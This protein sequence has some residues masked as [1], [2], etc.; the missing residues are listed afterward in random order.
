MPS[1]CTPVELSQLGWA[2]GAGRQGVLFVQ[3]KVA[4]AH[5]D[6]AVFIDQQGFAMGGSAAGQATQQLD[7]EVEGDHAEHPVL[8]IHR[9]REGD[10][11]V[12]AAGIL[13]QAGDDLPALR[14]VFGEGVLPERLEQK[15]PFVVK[16]VERWFRRQVHEVAGRGVVHPAD[17]RVVLEDRGEQGIQAEC[18]IQLAAHGAV[19]WNIAKPGDGTAQLAGAL[20]ILTAGEHPALAISQWAQGAQRRQWRWIVV[21]ALQ[22]QLPHGVYL[23][24]EQGQVVLGQLMAA[25]EGLRDIGAQAVEVDL[26]AIGT[27]ANGQQQGWQ[28]QDQ[29]GAGGQVHGEFAGR[30]S[31]VAKQYGS[32]RAPCLLPRINPWVD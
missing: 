18:G 4:L 1:Q 27:Q 5:H 23:G 22:Q 28:H 15:G 26:I 14:V 16:V 10:H 7:A 3:V 24:A 25:V 13:V 17:L 8:F 19:Q 12:L 11:Q 29:A 20:F 30:S 9:R 6:L 21:V 32:L 2:L 31:R